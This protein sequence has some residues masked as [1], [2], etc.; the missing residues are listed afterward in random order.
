MASYAIPEPQDAK[1][2]TETDR[3]TISMMLKT[4]KIKF[5]NDTFFKFQT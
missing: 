1:N 3:R 2:L 4:S 5:R